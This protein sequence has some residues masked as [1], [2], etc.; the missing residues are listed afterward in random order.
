[1]ALVAKPLR[2]NSAVSGWK[3]SW[4]FRFSRGISPDCSVISLF[5]PPGYTTLRS[6][7]SGGRIARFLD[8][9]DFHAV[10]PDSAPRPLIELVE[11]PGM[12]IREL[13]RNPYRDASVASRGI[14]E[15]LAQMAVV[16]PFQLVLDGHLHSLVDLSRQN[17]EVEGAN[18]LFRLDQ[19][20]IHAKFLRSEGGGFP[21]ARA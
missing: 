9:L 17:I 15:R 11:R 6:R 3:K 12:F 4:C 13:W 16:G 8:G 18:R 2:N 21:P 5:Q 7:G 20:Q 19:F 10:E 14:G 1:M